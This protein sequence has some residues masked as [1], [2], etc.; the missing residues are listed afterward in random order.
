[1]YIINIFLDVEFVIHIASNVP[2]YSAD[3][4]GCVSIICIKTKW[5]AR[6]KMKK[7]TSPATSLV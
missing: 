3:M 2:I 5:H 4:P 7:E 1:M 6:Y